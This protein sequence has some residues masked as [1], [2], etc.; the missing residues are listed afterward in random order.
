VSCFSP[1]ASNTASPLAVAKAIAGGV[2]I[3]L[4]SGP[5]QNDGASH[6]EP[7]L[8]RTTTHGE[9]FAP[10]GVFTQRPS[11]QYQRPRLRIHSPG[12]HASAFAGLAGTNSTRPGGGSES[13]GASADDGCAAYTG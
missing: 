9:Y 1:C 11:S 8:A 4:P 3:G 13:T 5:A 7:S 6:V 2:G 10:G 12:I